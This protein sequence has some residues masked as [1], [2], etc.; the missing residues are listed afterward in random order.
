MMR[1]VFDC[2][3]LLQAA[4]NP[5]GA[6][7]RCLH[8]VENDVVELVMSQATRYEFHDVI[9]RDRFRATFPKLTDDRIEDVCRF[10]D[11]HSTQYPVV[12]Q[13]VTFPR[14]PKDEKYLNLAIAADARYLVTRDHDLLDLMS[15]E[16][17]SSVNFRAAY[18][19]IAILEPAVF[20]ERIK[21][22]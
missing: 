11:L 8:A 15:L 18:P 21:T 12:S 22:T 1:C 13:N 14:D 7:G 3:I 4:A 17:E 9:R 19:T 16:D 6:S 5:T 10:L 2:V 20:L